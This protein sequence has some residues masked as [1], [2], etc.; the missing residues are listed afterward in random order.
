MGTRLLPAR[1]IGG[2]S[3]TDADSL[4][5]PTVQQII[6]A[7]RVRHWSFTDVE[8]GDGAALLYLNERVR[9]HLGEHGSQI[10]GLVGSTIQHSLDR[11]TGLL[12]AL[13]EDDV[14]YYTTT[15]EDGYAVHLDIDGVPYI[16]TDEPPIAGDPFGENG[17]TPGFPLPRDVVRLISVGAIYGNGARNIP[18][19]VIPERERYTR[20]PGRNPT[21]FVSGNRLVPVMPTAG[22]NTGD[23][24][25]DVTALQISYVAVPDLTALTDRIP[26]PKVLCEA[27]TAD[28]ALLFA[29][30]SPRCDKS[31][32]AALTIEA[33]DCA[34]AVAAASLD[35]LES[36]QQSSV[37]YKP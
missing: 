36:V 32:K 35:L 28:L 3:R 30:Q 25:N 31:D 16:D 17:A 8:L 6:D 11:G 26:L 29:R 9:T 4:A 24:W 33:R 12:V 7:A 10:E 37:L 2:S 22:H 15:A 14:P 19:D 27:L 18:I 34:A 13:D 23:R 20:A 1:L 5:G 21:A